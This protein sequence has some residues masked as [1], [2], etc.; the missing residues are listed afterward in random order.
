M[1]TD[2]ACPNRS[3][4]RYLPGLRKALAPAAPLAYTAHYSDGTWRTT[5]METSKQPRDGRDQARKRL[6]ITSCEVT[7]IDAHGFGHGVR[8]LATIT[9]NNALVLR[10]L[11]IMKDRNSELTVAY[12]SQLGRD[13]T[14]YDLVEPKS[15]SLRKEISS[16]VLDEYARAVARTESAEAPESESAEPEPTEDTPE[17]QSIEPASEP[18]PS[19][20]TPEEPTTSIGNR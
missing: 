12:P 4:A 17:P 7:P 15:E 3:E 6:V 9:L 16:R 13:K 1:S 11:R 14:T 2:G 10:S 20:A 8:G 18:S 19:E 5:S